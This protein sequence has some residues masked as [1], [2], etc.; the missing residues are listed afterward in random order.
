MNARAWLFG[1]FFSQNFVTATVRALQL[2]NPSNGQRDPG[3]NSNA[4]ITT[5]NYSPVVL[6][7]LLVTW[8][9]LA[10]NLSLCRTLIA[11]GNVL[12]GI[13][14]LIIF[15]PVSVMMIWSYIVAVRTS[16]GYTTDFPLASPSLTQEDDEPPAG[17]SQS[18][19]GDV[20]MQP[21]LQRGSRPSTVMVKRD[22]RA[23]FCS[24]CNLPKYD[25]THHCRTCKK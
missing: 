17:I 21:L 2:G 3:Q 1:R 7:V 14:Y 19:G 10:Y 4:I 24:K 13:A 9:Y 22:G 15:Q 11:D 8:S 25:R 5:V 16:P 6:V 20:G 23:R 12:K 18:L